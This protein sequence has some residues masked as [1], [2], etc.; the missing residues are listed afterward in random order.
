MFPFSSFILPFFFFFLYLY[1][2]IDVSWTYFGNH[3]KIYVNQTIMQFALN[4]HSDVGQQFLNETG[5]K[6]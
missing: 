4:L 3:F 2:K 1:G 5:K 6:L